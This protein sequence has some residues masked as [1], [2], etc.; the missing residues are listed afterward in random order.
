M[1]QGSIC[2]LE[3]C[4]L[5]TGSTTPGGWRDLE[6][7]K[8]EVLQHYGERP[9]CSPRPVFLQGFPILSQV[10]GHVGS[11]HWRCFSKHL[12]HSD[13][14]AGSSPRNMNTNSRRSA[15]HSEIDPDIWV[16]DVDNR[17]ERINGCPSWNEVMER[18]V[19]G[20]S[21]SDNQGL[22]G[23]LS[24]TRT[25]KHEFHCLCTTMK[26][27]SEHTCDVETQLLFPDRVGDRRA[28]RC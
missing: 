12:L 26:D 1:K 22:L 23:I 4:R 25:A 14:R 18:Y 8:C 28:V 13:V 27:D 10:G 24:H 9:A 19:L 11:R 6:F 7:K 5:T 21:V 16:G 17:D 2:R 20:E 3:Q 15:K